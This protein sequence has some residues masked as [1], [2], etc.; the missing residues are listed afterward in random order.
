MTLQTVEEPTLGL[1]TLSLNI[2]AQ[3][4]LQLA[5]LH[6]HTDEYSVIITCVNAVMF[7]CITCMV[8]VCVTCST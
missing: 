8:F 7:C 6:T 3:H 5:E 1:I 2:A 4:G